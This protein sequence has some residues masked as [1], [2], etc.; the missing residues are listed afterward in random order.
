MKGFRCVS[1]AALADLADVPAR[2][3]WVRNGELRLHLLD[4]S[5]GEPDS[6]TPVLLLPGITTPAIG[7][8]F[9]ARELTDLRPV[10]LD[11][12]GRGLSDS[13]ESFSLES[14]ADDAL[15]VVT[16][17][18]LERAVLLGH[19]MGARIAAVAAVRAA[20]RGI[21]LGGTVI[22][23]PP[24]SGPGREP[25]PT[26]LEVFLAQYDA[27]V[28]GTTPDEVAQS[29]PRW[30]RREQEVRARWL[31]SCQRE[32]I[33][34]THRGFECEDFFAVWPSVPGPTAFVYGADS[35]V[36]TARGAEEVRKNRSEV[37]QGIVPNAGHMVFWDSPRQAVEV[38]RE[39]LDEVLG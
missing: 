29:W 38:T 6:R 11:I 10:V 33:A 18:G 12:R 26:P 8:D 39:A 31:S 35:P 27:A 28:A 14:Y 7:M 1:Q 4:Y 30:P 25:Y 21:G 9:I 36:V 13:A 2:S 17:L 22:V 37:W 23:D 24:L 19:S 15:A 5:K 16:A 32:A 20:E 3:R 34:A